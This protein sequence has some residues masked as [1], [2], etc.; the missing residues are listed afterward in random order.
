[1]LTQDFIYRINAHWRVATSFGYWRRNYYDE[2]PPYDARTND[3]YR[4]ELRPF[5]RLYYD[6]RF[7]DV[8]VTHTFRADYRFYWTPGYTERWP[9]P[10]EFRARYMINVKIP[11]TRDK[12]NWVIFNDEV[13]S[14][15]DKYSA[16][17]AALQGKNWS[18]YKLTENRFS[19]YYRRRLEHLRADMDVGLMHQYWRE[20]KQVDFTNSFNI[21]IDLI[22]YDP[23]GKSKKE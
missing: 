10:F 18:V 19:V 11:F 7:G 6:H 17:D 16:S 14:A 13:L 20:V 15:V 12:L 1:V 3:S 22:V 21:M 8:L 5:Q 2:L 23:F 9:T 4:N